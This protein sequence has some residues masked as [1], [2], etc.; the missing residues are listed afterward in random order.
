MDPALTRRLAFVRYLNQLALVQSVAPEPM[1][2]AA[3][4]GFHDAAELF[5]QI[6]SEHLN[7]GTSDSQF[8]QYFEILGTKVQGGSLAQ[9]EGMRRLN[10]ARVALKHHGTHPSQLDIAAFRSVAA[11]F[12]DQ[13][14][15]L[16]FGVAFESISL[17]AFV[18][19]EPVRTK[20]ETAQT[21]L[22]E[23]RLTD[24][25]AGTTIAF[26]L[27]LSD[28]ESRKRSPLWRSPFAFGESFSFSHFDLADLEQF[29]RKSAG[30][31]RKL[32]ESVESMQEALKVVALGVDYRRYS[33]FKM[34]APGFMKTMDGTYHLHWRQGTSQP[35][36]AEAQFCIDFVIEAAL[37]IREF[38]YDVQPPPWLRQS[39]PSATT[40]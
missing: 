13:N 22:S 19:P 26:D 27:L 8:M 40:T 32:I 15:P 6:A 10:R 24:A 33:R 2:S 7:V 25:I 12:F 21:D 35:S 36:T 14:T 20:L 30:V 23:G 31:V 5:L 38:D 16:I 1:A 28:Y 39:G 4:L 34:L 11:D 17:I 3:L 37:K 9:K 18:S 29:S